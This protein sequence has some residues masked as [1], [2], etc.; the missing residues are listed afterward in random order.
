MSHAVPSPS[1]LRYVIYMNYSKQAKIT[2][3]NMV[4]IS[5]HP[6]IRRPMT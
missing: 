4:I 5:N 1:V 6:G 2:L 3:M